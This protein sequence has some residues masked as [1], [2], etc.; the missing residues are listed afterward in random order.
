M[1]D[2][3][4]EEPTGG[5][6]KDMNEEPESVLDKRDTLEEVSDISDSVD[7]VPEVLNPDSEDRDVSP[8]SWDT[9]TSE[10]HPSTEMSCSALSSLSPEQN[11]I[12]GRQIPSVIDDSSSTCST[13]SSR[14]VVMNG[15][16]RG[17]ISDHKKQKSPNKYVLF[18][19]WLIAA[20]ANNID[21]IFLYF[22]LP[23]GR[24]VRASHLVM[25]Q[26]NVLMIHR[27]K[28]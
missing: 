3:T 2:K 25:Q 13:D 15:P 10:V 1:Q 22:N 9:D 23:E 7:C 20:D 27:V 5:E 12:V 8:V 17:N 19:H 4:S 28:Y 14:S 26:L 6:G 18:N 21:L 24:T 16:Y 11:G